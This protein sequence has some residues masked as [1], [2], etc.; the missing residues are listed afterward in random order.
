[1]L[2]V[3]A[4]ALIVTVS[5]PAAAKRFGFAT[6]KRRI[7]DS[8]ESF[9][10]MLDQDRRKWVAEVAVGSGAEGNLGFSIGYLLNVPQGFE[11]YAGFGTRNGPVLHYTGS[12]RY[13]LPFFNRHRGYVGG[14]YLLQQHP[15]LEMLS[16]NVFSDVGYK[17]IVKHTFHITFSV[18]LQYNLDRS[19]SSG[20]VLRGDDVDPDFLQQNLDDI[21]DYRFLAALRFSRAF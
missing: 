15:H 3:V 19:V 10:E 7:Y 21:P 17:W 18:G 9:G 5:A 6:P 12:F 11:L 4:I 16:H 14:G 2:R 1:M 20:S 13:F 8:N